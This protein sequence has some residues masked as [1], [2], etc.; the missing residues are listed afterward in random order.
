M[1]AALL[2]T[3][4]PELG[5]ATPRQ[6]AALVGVAPFNADSGQWRGQRRI[7]GGRA[8]VRAGLYMAALTGIRVLRAFYQRLRAAGK[9]P[10]V[11]LVAAM[12]KLL[13]ILNAILRDQQPWANPA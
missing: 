4:L 6:L 12:H 2:L 3:S 1:T 10:K 8:D 5:H 7:L 9:R 13:S 11:A